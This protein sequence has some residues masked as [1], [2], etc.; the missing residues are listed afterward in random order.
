MKWK[1]IEE[2]KDG[3][4]NIPNDWLFPYYYEALN[5]LFRIENGLRIFVYLVLKNEYGANWQNLSITSDDEAQSTIGKIAKQRMNQTK[6]LGYLGYLV[7]CPLMYMT[8]GELITL[9]TAEAYW[10]H[11]RAYLPG[12]K[13]IIRNK[14]DEISAVRNAL[15]HFRPIKKDDL[16]LVKQN[17][18]HVL[19]RIEVLMVDIM[20][21]SNIVPTNTR[22]AWYVDLRSMG[23]EHCALSFLQSDDESWVRIVCEYDCPVLGTSGYRRNPIYRV[24]N[25]VTPT[26]LKKFP[27]LQSHI[28]ILY[29]SV[30]YRTTDD[31]S[32]HQFGKTIS[33]L[34]NRAILNTEHNAIKEALESVLAMIL[35][36]TKLVQ[37]DN[38]ARGELIQGVDVTARWHEYR[39]SDGF[40]SVNS[41]SLNCNVSEDAPVEYWGAMSYAEDDYLTATTKYPWMPVEVAQDDIPF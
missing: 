13:E 26:I 38:L 19:S 32:T 7:P 15:A 24:L 33:M 6:R 12:S 21:C 37:E 23:N 34:F 16:D 14:F 28:I 40:W 39:N 4:V 36:E 17:A 5:A 1:S 25:L 8:T 18:I 31:N 30:K 11:F 3:S 35:E 9:I 20:R 2:K 22:E 29:E 10:K 41:N 27:V